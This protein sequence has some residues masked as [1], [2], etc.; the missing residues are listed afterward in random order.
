MTGDYSFNTSN[1]TSA[2]GKTKLHEAGYDAL[3]TAQVSC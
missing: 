2:L 3:I 1:E